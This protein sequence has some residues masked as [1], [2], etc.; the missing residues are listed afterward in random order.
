MIDSPYDFFSENKKD[1]EYYNFITTHNL[2]VF[3]AYTYYSDKLSLI[4]DGFKT[5]IKYNCLIHDRSKLLPE[6]FLIFRKRFFP[7]NGLDV[8]GD[9]AF[10][11]ALQHFYN[12]NPYRPEYWV[13]KI[14]ST[15]E[16][17]DEYIAELMLDWIATSMETGQKCYD[18][19][20]LN[21]ESLNLHSTTRAKI[22]SALTDIKAID[23]INNLN[24]GL[25][26]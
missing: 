6:E 7:V 8:I 19:Y 5:K 23:E 15:I 2:N 1:L 16:M 18:W 24:Y 10:N 14:G 12:N 11:T 3:N 22:E 9:Q 17:P 26:R 25:A 13:S 21:K 4:Y 20:E